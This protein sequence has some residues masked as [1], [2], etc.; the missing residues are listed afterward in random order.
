MRLRVRSG[1]VRVA[2]GRGRFVRSG[3]V[4]VKS[5]EEEE[6]GAEALSKST[7]TVR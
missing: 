7:V 5:V 2:A 1:A 4:E 6:A 3:F